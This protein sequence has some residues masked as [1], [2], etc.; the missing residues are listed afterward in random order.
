MT[1]LW[2]IA[3]IVALRRGSRRFQNWATRRA[4]GVY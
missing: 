4:R 1:A 2:T 3:I